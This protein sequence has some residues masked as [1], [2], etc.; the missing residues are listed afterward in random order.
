MSRLPVI[1]IAIV[2]AFLTFSPA[3]TALVTVG[4]IA[5]GT[6]PETSCEFSQSYD[7]IQIV[8]GAAPS[9]TVPVSGVLTSWSTNAAAGSGQTMGMKVFRPIGPGQF[10]VVGH[11]GPNLLA[12]SVINTFPVNIPVL[13]GDILGVAVT[14][15]LPEAGGAP[16]ACAFTTLNPLDVIAYKSGSVPDGG[17][18]VP[19][20]ESNFNE[21][22]LNVSATLLPPPAI[23]AITPAK[24]SIKG[25][26]NVVLTGLNFAS[27]TG[28]T[29]GGVPAVFAV[30]SEGQITAVSPAS[31]KITKVPVTVTTIAGAATAVQTFSYEGCKV[32]GLGGKKL[33]A[34]KKTLR[35][36]DCKVGKVKKTGDATANTGKVKKQNPKPGK[37]LAPGTKVNV[38]LG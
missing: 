33:K 23:S 25:G 10:L 11:N 18:V 13:A 28:V 7:E 26:S 29:F 19:E 38:T 5:P 32:P 9:Y 22:R 15:G 12:P 8:S 16:T 4:Q 31:K 20:A 24:G 35:N 2:G 1:A 36:K 21:S 6:N 30:N 34:A 27:V 17:V 37:I 14:P 3:A